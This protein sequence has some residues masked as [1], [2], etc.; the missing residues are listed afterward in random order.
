MQV[1]DHPLLSVLGPEERRPVGLAEATFSP[2]ETLFARGQVMDLVHFIAEGSVSQVALDASLGARSVVDTLGAGE[3]VGAV[4]DM[5]SPLSRFDYM[6]ADTVRAFAMSLD[7]FRMLVSRSRNFNAAVL[8]YL[9]AKAR[10]FEDRAVAMG[11]LDISR[12]VFDRKLL[13]QATAQYILSKRVLPIALQGSTLTVA[14]AALEEGPVEADLRRVF[15]ATKVVFVRVTPK[16]FER[17]YRD[18]A[19]PLLSMQQEDDLTWFRS[20]KTREYH[21]SFEAATDVPTMDSSRKESE[22]DGASVIA[23]TNKIIGEAMDL[24]ASD[25]HFEPYPGGMDVRYR[26]DGELAKRPERVRSGYLQAVLSR[27]KVVAG[28]DI[29]EK[30]K[31]QDGR[32]TATCQGKTVDIRVSTVPTR[33]GEKIVMRILDPST[34][35]LDLES[36][37]N[38]HEVLRAVK[39]MVGQP[40]GMILVAGPTGAG[41]TTTVYSMLLDRKT[42]PV[43]IM[44]IEDPIEYSLRGV[45]QVQ[46]N[47][48][49]GLDFPN[50]IRSFLRQDPDVII[51]GETRDA[52]TARAAL[53]AGLTGHLVISTV[54]ANNVFATIYR[55]K[56]MGMEPFVIANSVIGVLSQRLVR[57]ICPRCSRTH[58]YHRNLIEPLKLPDIAPA[59]GDYYH[60]RK[61][62]GCVHCNFKGYK[63]RAAAF[64]SLQVREDLKP[65]LA[66]NVPYSQLAAEAVRLNAYVPMRRYAAMLLTAGITTP[67]E[68]S[69]ILFAESDEGASTD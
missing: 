35:L 47:L 65:M 46:R 43:N 61:G 60:F 27:V 26:L 49:V 42:L 59:D 69:R 13:N 51:V 57:R 30:R 50:A 3:V 32:I 4:L 24:G 41:K 53:E 52:E 7:D 6:A 64:E 21:V 34:M 39:W 28:L 29:A 23:L 2:R 16:E 14:S 15:A 20:V 58:Q 66:A 22:L 9:A 54:H 48:H 55:L 19:Q 10:L 17:A 1:S 40:Y 45:T 68:I 5:E 63:G 44:S 38:S 56:E 12:I 25:I 62:V 37:I 31:P 36:L 11:K 8:K 67:E 18:A 33:F